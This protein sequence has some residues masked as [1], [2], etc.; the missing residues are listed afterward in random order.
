MCVGESERGKYEKDTSLN[1]PSPPF[2]LS[3]GLLPLP[4]LDP[5]PGVRFVQFGGGGGEAPLPLHSAQG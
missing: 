1:I 4:A 5:D 2:L 3:L